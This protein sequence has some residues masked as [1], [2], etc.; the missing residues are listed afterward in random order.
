M[1]NNISSMIKLIW[2]E[3]IFAFIDCSNDLIFLQ[4][5]LKAFEMPI[6]STD[7][8]ETLKNNLNTFEGSIILL[9]ITIIRHMLCNLLKIQNYG[10]TCKLL[11]VLSENFLQSN[12]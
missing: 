9:N 2:S 11:N 5:G 3:N 12:C 10:Y 6:L 7:H 8:K 1:Y 4:H